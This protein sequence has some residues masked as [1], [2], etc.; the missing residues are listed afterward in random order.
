MLAFGGL[1]IADDL[2]E[3]SGR[4]LTLPPADAVLDREHCSKVKQVGR[5]THQ[6]GLTI[7]LF[8]RD[9]RGPVVILNLRSHFGAE[10]LS[11][12]QAEFI[13]NTRNLKPT[14][15]YYYCQCLTANPVLNS[16][17]IV[18]GKKDLHRLQ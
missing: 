17:Y 18:I 11:A 7:S 16:F 10:I 8:H 13:G 9:A 4:R 12:E 2:A 3:D 1:S 14:K 6:P 15:Y 5:G